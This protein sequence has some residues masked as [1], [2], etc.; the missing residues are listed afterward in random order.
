MTNLSLGRIARG[1]SRHAYTVA[2]GLAAAGPRLWYG[3][4]AG[5]RANRGARRELQRLRREAET[6]NRIT[7]DERHR[8][9]AQQ[10]ENDGYVVLPRLDDAVRL[11]TIRHAVA[12]GFADPARSVDS[13]NGA[14]R[15]LLE[16]EKIIPQLGA[17]L[18][19]DVCRTVAAYYECGLRVES[20]RI[21]RNHHVPDIDGNTDDRFSNTFHHDNCPVSGLRVFVLLSDGV[22]RETGAFRF[23][24][25]Q[26]SERLVRSPGFFHRNMMTRGMRRR[27]LDKRTLRYFEGDAGDTC[28][29]N[30]QQCL[31]AASV[32][33]EGSFRDILQF[34]VYPD[35]GPLRSGHELT[36]AVAPDVQVLAMR[37]ATP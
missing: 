6:K 34:E 11:A 26:T 10:L 15:F 8:A 20:V 33:R 29:V 4:T 17:L 2:Q 35:A 5:W 22:S 3:N 7:G 13:P 16:P 32:P 19:D 30:T 36:A 27:L 14:T 12:E 37:V 9:R 24:D 23:H 1:V 31:H 28:I 21:W 25:R 18:T